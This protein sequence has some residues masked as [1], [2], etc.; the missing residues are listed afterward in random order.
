M[1]IKLTDGT[2]NALN[3]L[4]EN[5]N[6]TLN[7][8]NEVA[9]T[10]IVSAHLTSLVK[11]GLATAEKIEVPVMVMKLVNSYTL[12]DAGKVFMQSDSE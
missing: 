11:N 3:V 2:R 7:Q 5:D 9:D 10:K 12:T 8:L 4:R 1:A 6:A